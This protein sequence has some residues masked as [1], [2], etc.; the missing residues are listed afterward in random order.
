MNAATN[1]TR[2]TIA[3][4]HRNNFIR[5]K[6]ALE[7]ILKAAS[8]NDEI[9][10]INNASTDGS[11]QKIGQLY[12]DIKIITNTCNSG[13]GHCCNQAMRKGKGKYFLLCN[14][15]LILPEECLNQFEQHLLDEPNA[16]MIG[17]QLLTPDGNHMNSFGGYPTFLSQIDFIGRIPRKKTLSKLSE[18]GTIRGACLAINKQATDAIGMYDEDFYF[19]FEETEW[20]VRMKKNGWKVLI[21]PDIKVQHIG[22]ASTNSVYAGSRI[23]FFRSRLTFWNKIF[24][25]HLVLIL[26]L[27]N[28]PKLLIDCT[29]YLTTTIA[30]LNL[31]KRLRRKF[32]DRITVIT[33]LMLGKPKNWGLPNKCPKHP[34]SQL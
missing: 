20:C 13:Y 24:P 14:N 23:E 26:Y 1:E 19:Y 7:S 30:T 31:N 25:T 32:I 21:A 18:V 28:I 15:D 10:I 12:P 8:N 27:W 22:G 34:S 5:L 33:W 9:I 2:F 3:I 17:P 11:D 29:F 6:N 16:G 4:I